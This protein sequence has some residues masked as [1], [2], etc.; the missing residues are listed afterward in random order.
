MTI[1]EKCQAIGIALPTYYL[2]IKQGMTPEEA[3]STPNKRP[4]RRDY[5]SGVKQPEKQLTTEEKPVINLGKHKAF[6]FESD[7][8]ENHR[9]NKQAQ[10]YGLKVSGG[11]KSP[12]NKVNKIPAPAARPE[13]K[14]NT[15]NTEDAEFDR[16]MGGYTA[17]ILTTPKRGEFKYQIHGKGVKLYTSSAVRFVNQI[18]RICDPQG[19]IGFKVIEE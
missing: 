14:Y 17:V 8:Q 10:N 16:I 11:I 1:K 5:R 3:L 12:N 6:V 2:R 18:I 4:S 15:F 19:K 7:F 13:P 9:K